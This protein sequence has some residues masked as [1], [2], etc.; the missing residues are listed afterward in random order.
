MSNES[1]TAILGLDV[2]TKRIGV[3]VSDALQIGAYPLETIEGSIEQK[4]TKITSILEERKISCA[5]VGMPYDFHGDKAES[6]ELVEK[7]CTKLCAFVFKKLNRELEIVFVDERLTS[8]QAEHVL[9]GSKLKD[10]DR[11]RAADKIAAAIILETF[12]QSRSQRL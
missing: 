5:A 8:K 9:S 11:S 10:V 4:L 12:L 3:A 1:H 6:A 2:G 7:F